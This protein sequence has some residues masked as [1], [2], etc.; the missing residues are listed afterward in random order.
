MRGAGKTRVR[1]WAEG[2]QDS[3]PLL[4]CDPCYPDHRLL[5][6]GCLCTGLKGGRP[7]P[8]CILYFPQSPTGR[9]TVLARVGSVCTHT[10][11]RVCV[12]SNIGTQIL[13]LNVNPIPA[14]SRAD[15]SWVLSSCYLRWGHRAT[16]SASQEPVRNADPQATTPDSDLSSKKAP[17]V[18]LLV[19][20]FRYSRRPNGK[21]Y[22]LI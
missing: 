1:S 4:A 10:C 16:A 18:T 20:A 22:E 12:F 5:V 21:Q 17:S 19:W 6:W 11:V 9:G 7:K 13:I 8:G 15:L 2:L 3:S 14:S